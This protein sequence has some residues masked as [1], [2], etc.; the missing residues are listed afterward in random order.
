MPPIHSKLLTVETIG[1]KL[2]KS[3]MNRIQNKNN[4]CLNFGRHLRQV[5]I[6]WGR[7]NKIMFD[8]FTTF[9]GCEHVQRD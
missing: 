1:V 4:V 5:Y 2:N 3:V 7:I 9:G 8:K 6:L